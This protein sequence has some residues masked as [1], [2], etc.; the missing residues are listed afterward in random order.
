[1]TD[2]EKKLAEELAQQ[3]VEKLAAPAVLP[4]Q[5]IGEAIAGHV[6]SWRWVH[7]G[8]LQNK[9]TDA[10]IDKAIREA[11]DSVEEKIESIPEEQR[12]APP[13][14]IYGPAVQAL[15]YT[16]DNSELRE[17]FANLIAASMDSERVAGAHPSF[18]DI[19]RQITSDEA[20]ILKLL[21]V[22]QHDVVGH[23]KFHVQPGDGSYTYIHKNVSTLPSR[24][25]C[26]HLDMGTVYISN[27]LRLGLVDVPVNWWYSDSTLYAELEAWFSEW[28]KEYNEGAV[29]LEKATIRLTALGLQFVRTCIPN[30]EGEPHA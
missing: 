10:E 5:A 9:M 14:N 2:F 8:R 7:Q 18:V 26:T 30:E 17:M 25:G 24:S 1:M 23:V 28:K 27:L 20:K 21:S 11:A 3:S 16:I 19:I 12:Q 22:K 29:S 15:G 13:L 4:L 6:K